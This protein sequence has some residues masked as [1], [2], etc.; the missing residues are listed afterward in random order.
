VLQLAAHE[1][2]FLVSGLSGGDF[3]LNSHLPTALSIG[4]SSL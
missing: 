3:R 4:I 2:L 1:Y